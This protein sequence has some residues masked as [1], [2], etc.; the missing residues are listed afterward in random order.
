[1]SVLNIMGAEGH[2]PV[3]FDPGTEA[4]EEARDLF[5]KTV[6]NQGYLAFTVTKE[7]GHKTGE[8]IKDFD[9]TAEE[10]LVMPPMAGG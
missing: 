8:P 5:N 2:T 7:N 6:H 10:L 1:M 3:V 4:E 9:P